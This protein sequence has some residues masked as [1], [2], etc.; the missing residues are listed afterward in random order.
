MGF[1][2]VDNIVTVDH[3]HNKFANT[4]VSYNPTKMV[5]SNELTIYSAFRRFRIKDRKRGQSAKRLKGDNCPMIYA[6]K[7][8]D[9]LSTTY[10]DIYSLNLNLLSII[11]KFKDSQPYDLI[12]PLPSRHNISSI[13][14][15]RLHRAL[16]G[17]ILN[18][19]LLRKINLFEAKASIHNSKIDIKDKRHI[20]DA[21]SKQIKDNG[22][23]IF[24]PYSVKDLKVALR[25][26]IPPITL[27][28]P[29]KGLNPNT[30]VLVDD[31]VSSGTSML[32]A[33]S[34]LKSLY[35]DAT[36]IGFSLFSS[37]I[38]KHS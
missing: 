18:Q 10:K 3:S 37:T 24:A 2:I 16:P 21:L 19:Q 4:T 34:I 25:D 29:T 13:I 32:S 33:Y 15:R 26:C 36:I 38:T 5:H 1:S 17:S 7:G 8:K 14:S 35:P 31:V 27:N 23:S 20:E 30:I 6:I 11:E 9:G 12:I 28:K 22:G